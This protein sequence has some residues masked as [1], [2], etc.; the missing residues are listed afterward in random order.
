MIAAVG[1]KLVLASHNKGKLREISA[2]LAP[3]GIEAVA[4]SEF[5]LA[6]P[7]ETE[8]SFAG[9]ALL[10]ARFAAEGAGLPALSDDSGLCVAALGGEPGV[11]TADWAETPNGRDWMLAM[12]KVEQRL[13]ALGS[14]VSRAAEFV[15]V[16]A[17][18]WPNGR[19][20]T[21]E[22]RMPGTLV[23]PPRGELGFGYDPVFVPEGY[24]QT[25]AEMDPAEKHAISHRARAFAKLKAAL[26]GG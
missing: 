13:A 24:T 20:E 16:L 7:V 17:L 4:A 11:Y 6:E 3:F 1:P 15:C 14:D 19:A 22:G 23:W 26:G 9:N 8:D 18:V 21:F 10:K 2:L 5:G 12:T 25:F